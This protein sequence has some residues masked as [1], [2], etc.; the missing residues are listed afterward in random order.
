MRRAEGAVE[1]LDLTV[2]HAD[3]EASLADVD[4]LSAW[5]GGHWVTVREV[6]RLAR[7]PRVVIAD[8]GGGSGALAA[9]IIA[10]LTRDGRRARVVV[11]DRAARPL[12]SADVLVVR[13]DATALPLR[14]G[15]V[16]IVTASLLLHH[17]APGAVVRCLGEMR[18]AARMAVV[19]NDLLRTRATLVL[20]WLATR[21]FARHRF[22][23]HDGPL[24]VRR[25]YAASE[26]TAL[27]EKAGVPRLAIRRYPWLGR[28]VAVTL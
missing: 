3:R 12:A 6:R 1:H 2:P 24:S 8:I 5:F 10:A 16:D 22:S 15:A 26:L 23:R 21:L 9:Q 17:L 28:L 14:D 13:A 19:V 18:A 27:A 20:V 4:R 25:A 11:V 7:G